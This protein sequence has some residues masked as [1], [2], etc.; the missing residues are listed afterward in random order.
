L[1]NY[2]LP[3]FDSI[4]PI[5]S[6]KITQQ[7]FYRIN[8]GATQLKGVKPDVML[9]D[10]YELLEV[11]EKNLDNP[12][13]WDEIA[14]AKYEEFKNI[15]YESLIKSSAKRLKADAQ[16]N[17]IQQQAKEIK[18]KKDE[19]KYNLKLE[20]F[21]AEQKAY[22][23]Q[24]KKYEDLRKEIKGF[25]VSLVDE[26]KTRLSNDTVR[27]NRETRWTKNLAKDIYVHEASNVVNDL[28]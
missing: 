28:K 17:L 8:G 24:N 22:R 15:N 4:K 26:D 25:E 13:A 27:L 18:A 21:R 12:L 6:V 1:D 10:P 19:S 23:D 11:G 16:F 9:P 3:Q 7:K 14:K 2:L 5:G 20:K